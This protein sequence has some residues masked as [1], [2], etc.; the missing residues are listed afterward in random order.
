MREVELI[1]R[2]H[3]WQMSILKT[4]IAIES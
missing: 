4:Q 2:L 1:E 3:A